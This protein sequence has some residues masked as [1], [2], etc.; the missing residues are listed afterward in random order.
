MVKPD[1][2]AHL[3]PDHQV[4]TTIRN[5]RKSPSWKRLWRRL[6]PTSIST[7]LYFNFR[8]TRRPRTTRVSFCALLDSAGWWVNCVSELKITYSSKR[9]PAHL[10]IPRKR[11]L[12]R[13]PR[14]RRRLWIPRRLRSLPTGKIKLSH[15]VI[16]KFFSPAQLQATKPVQFDRNQ[17]FHMC[18]NAQE[19]HRL[20][21]YLLLS[22]FAT[23]LLQAKQPKRWRLIYMNGLCLCW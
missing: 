18:A 11:R 8:P 22:F 20:L 6:Q 13:W 23:P 19:S 2:L 21:F 3:S 15:M 1:P 7:Y 5:Y 12:T 10:Q 4:S 9:L 16:L 17:I 14:P